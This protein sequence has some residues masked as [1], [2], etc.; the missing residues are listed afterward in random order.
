[1]SVERVLAGLVR[2]LLQ[3]LRCGSGTAAVE[4]AFVFPLLITL[5][6]GIYAVGSVMHSISS[7][8]Y[9]LEDTARMLQ[10]NP[11]MTQADLQAAI[12]KKLGYLGAQSFTITMNTEKDGYGSNVAHLKV[13]YPY[14]VAIPFIPKYEGAYSLTSEVFI[15]IAR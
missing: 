14:T 5:I 8:R 7:V 6:L 1:M 9:A 11:A 10:I 13:S 3:G 12:Q 15:A 2:R 4:F